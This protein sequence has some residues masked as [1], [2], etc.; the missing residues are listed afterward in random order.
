ECRR[1]GGYLCRREDGY[2]CRRE[3]GYPCRREGGSHCGREGPMRR[4]GGSLSLASVRLCLGR[5]D[6]HFWMRPASC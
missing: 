4:G 2:P 1:E 5:E 3:D 6:D